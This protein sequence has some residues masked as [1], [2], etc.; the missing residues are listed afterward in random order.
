[1]SARRGQ[2][3][4][5]GVLFLFLTALLVTI[6]LNVGQRTRDRIEAQ[7]AADSAAYSNAV[8]TAR[9]L[10]Q[11]S[12]INRTRVSIIV[13][14]LGVQSLISWSGHHVSHLA[15][16]RSALEMAETPYIP[17]CGNPFCPMSACSC[18]ELSKLRSAE[19]DVA[20]EQ[21]RVQSDWD[22]LDTD[23]AQYVRDL[24]MATLGLYNMT[25]DALAALDDKLKHQLLAKAIVASANPGLD[26]PDK[27]DSKSR[28][29]TKDSPRCEDVGGLYC[30]HHEEAKTSRTAMMG[31][32]GW[33]FVTHRDEKQ[34]LIEKKLLSLVRPHNPM[35]G[36]DPPAKAGGAGVGPDREA[37]QKIG[38]SPYLHYIS[39]DHGGTLTLAWPAAGCYPSGGTATIGAAWVKTNHGDMGGDEHK[40]D[41]ASEPRSRHDLGG[42]GA[43]R[44]SWPWTFEYNFHELGKP[45]ND[46]GQP[47]LYALVERRFQHQYPW[48]LVTG[49]GFTAKG[50]TLQPGTRPQLALSS[51]IAYYHRPNAWKEPPNLWNP[52]WRATL[53]APDDDLAKYV[54]KAGY[55]P[56]ADAMKRLLKAGMA[57]TQ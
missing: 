36:I 15:A 44:D 49:Y 38:G 6:T 16:T 17:C 30:S 46:F 4:L 39:E 12:L 40:Y 1:M 11:I 10:N 48:D 8:V 22:R 42:H 45:K 29:E 5:L 53:V 35:V 26:A 20:R 18:A 41:R 32:R 50:A 19:A 55:A 54:A 33:N 9:T 3:L 57:G 47:K 23:A 43:N 25:E 56:E 34:D 27:G 24:F 13:V 14:M 52:F 28:D 7:I 31:T 21:Q 2:T 51:A 37:A